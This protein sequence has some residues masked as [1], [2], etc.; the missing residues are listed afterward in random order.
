M[1]LFLIDALDLSYIFLP[2]FKK[3]KMKKPFLPALIL[4]A[5][6]TFFAASQSQGQIVGYLNLQ[7]SAGD[8]L[9]ANQ[10][11]D[12]EGDLLNDDFT[13]GVLAG[14]TF[15]EWNA[16][17][18]QFLPTSVFNGTSWSINYDFP[19][20]ETGAVFNSPAS[21]TITLAGGVN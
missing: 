18:S 10:F 4:I 21:T 3:L 16:A 5:T 7:I 19:P 8:N 17:T 20:D 9:L 11:S 15:T 1:L 14:S 6:T 13:Q 12:G 2:S